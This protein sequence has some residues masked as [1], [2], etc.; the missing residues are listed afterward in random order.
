M[1]LSQNKVQARSFY[2][3]M[4]LSYSFR[5]KMLSQTKPRVL[6]Y[7][8]SYPRSYGDVQAFRML[9]LPSLFAKLS[10]F[11]EY[12]GVSPDTLFPPRPTGSLQPRRNARLGSRPRTCQCS[13]I[14]RIVNLLNVATPYKERS[15]IHQE[16]IVPA[17]IRQL[18]VSIS[19]VPCFHIVHPSLRFTK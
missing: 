4:V 10:E 11:F 7:F 13:D 19:Q 14:A 15:T 8:Q 9:G 16:Y 5:Q 2:R 1:H 17:C 3:K 18:I 6:R 12:F